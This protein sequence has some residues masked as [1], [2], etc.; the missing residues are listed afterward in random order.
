[1]ASITPDEIKQFILDYPELN[2]VKGVDEFTPEQIERAI[3]FVIDDF[4]TT[5]P[6]TIIYSKED[7]PFRY[8]L[9]LGT[10]CH[11]YFGAAFHQERNHLPVSTGG[12]TVDDSAH[13]GNYTSLA[14]NLAAKYQDKLI[15]IKISLNLD[16]GW[17]GVRS[18]FC[19]GG[20]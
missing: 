14:G 12:V 17:G 18:E 1:M 7:F 4:N 10:V 13:S 9:L 3:D 8:L 5:P 16:N 15:R 11:L 19:Y 20:W 2:N 6:L